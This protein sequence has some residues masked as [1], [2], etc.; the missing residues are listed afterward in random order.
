MLK[1]VELV[2]QPATARR[3]FFLAAVVGGEG[4]H[5]PARERP[6]ARTPTPLLSRA[7]IRPR[8]HNDDDPGPRAA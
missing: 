1:V 5:P 6:F 2:W 4:A 7:R 8:P 3:S